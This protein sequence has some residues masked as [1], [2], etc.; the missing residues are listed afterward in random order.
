MGWS[1]PSAP[2]EERLEVPRDTLMEW[3]EPSAPGEE[4][5]EVPCDTLMGQP[6]PPVLGEAGQ[7]PSRHPADANGWAV[8]LGQTDTFT[9]FG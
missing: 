9:N 7:V 8:G 1:E 2:G 4:R 5:L 3:S 6:G